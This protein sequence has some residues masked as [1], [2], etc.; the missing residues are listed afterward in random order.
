MLKCHHCDYVTQYPETCPECGSNKIMRV[1]FGTERLVKELQLLFPEASIGRLDSDIGK[2]RYNIAKT[3][4]E[5][6]DRKFDILVGTQMI[7]K[8]HDFPAVTLVGVVLADI[9]LSLP[10][11][12][13]SERTFEL[14]AQAV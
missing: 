14:I 7:A 2:V 11:Y 6:R 12:R 3:L 5:F 8:G 1:G 9:G 13:A 4:Q 10:T